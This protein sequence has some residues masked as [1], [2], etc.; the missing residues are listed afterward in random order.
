M[1]LFTLSCTSHPD[2]CGGLGQL[3]SFCLNMVL[4][5][6]IGSVLLG[7]FSL[8]NVFHLQPFW[9]IIVDITL[10]VVFLPLAVIVFFAPLW[11]IHS[12]MLRKRRIYED[13]FAERI[14]EFEERTKRLE[15]KLRS[16]LDKEELDKA[17]SAKEELEIVQVLHPNKTSYPLWPFDRSIALIFLTPQV[18]T[19][20]TLLV[21]LAPMIKAF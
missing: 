16:S 12:Q 4:P 13:E 10:V 9:I 15:E 21:R 3:G 7:L 14:I 20:L 11:N 5:L 17:K 2:N 8:F 6:L 19:I 1:E 18:I